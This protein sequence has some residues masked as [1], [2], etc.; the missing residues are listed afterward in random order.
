MKKYKLH[1]LR[2]IE[3]S[4]VNEFLHLYE[5]LNVDLYT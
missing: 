2:S 3:H 1:L 4:W 5:A